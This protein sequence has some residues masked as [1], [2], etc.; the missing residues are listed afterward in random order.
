MANPVAD[1]KTPALIA[2]ALIAVGIAIAATRGL[3]HGS[4][5]GGVVAALGAIPGCYGMWKGIQQDT[6]GTLAI[7]V[8]SVLAALT[9][10][11]VLIVLHVVSFVLH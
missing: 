2:F 7:S 11:G 1:S 9:I 5:P 8:T 10:G 3:I 6:Q 4:I